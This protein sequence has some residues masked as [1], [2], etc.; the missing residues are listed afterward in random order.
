MNI[1]S[2]HAQFPVGPAIK[3]LSGNSRKPMHHAALSQNN[4]S[5]RGMIFAEVYH[6]SGTADFITKS[7]TVCKHS[8]C[9]VRWQ[10]STADILKTAVPLLK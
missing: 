4:E 6:F 9:Y 5:I 10:P 1:Q 2:L 7:R 3:V 8:G